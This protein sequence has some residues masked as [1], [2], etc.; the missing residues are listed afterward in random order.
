MMPGGDPQFLSVADPSRSRSPSTSSQSSHQG[1]EGHA[2]GLALGYGPNGR[3]HGMFINHQGV[4]CASQLNAS[5]RVP[6]SNGSAS[7]LPRYGS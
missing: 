3:Q 2:G 7:S 5:R 4:H 6:S 1:S